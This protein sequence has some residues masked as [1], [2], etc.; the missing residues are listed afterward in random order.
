MQ[1]EVGKLGVK[2]AYVRTRNDEEY[3]SI[4]FCHRPFILKHFAFD[5]YENLTHSGT[6]PPVEALRKNMK[7]ME[8]GK[9]VNAEKFS[10]Q[11]AENI[12]VYTLLM[13][14][15]TRQIQYRVLELLRKEFRL[16]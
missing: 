12:T 13:L 6:L 9:I 8:P 5:W 2:I 4:K 11:E 16:E 7:T 3:S 15:S 1:S 10:R 14:R